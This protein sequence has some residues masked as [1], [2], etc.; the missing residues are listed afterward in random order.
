MSSA[1]RAFVST[2]W[3]VLSDRGFPSSPFEKDEALAVEIDYFR[4]VE[5]RT[6]PK[7][8]KTKFA[9]WDVLNLDKVLIDVV[10]KYL[11]L[12]DSQIVRALICKK[13]LGK[14]EKPSARFMISTVPNSSW[15]R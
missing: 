13:E 3:D 15:K 5:N 11:G 6:W 1:G 9:R 10:F 8:A 4:Q 12:D 14:N 2:C 7:S